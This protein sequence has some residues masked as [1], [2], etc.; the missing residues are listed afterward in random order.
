MTQASHNLNYE[1]RLKYYYLRFLR[2][3][4]EPH[5][6]ALGMAFGVFAGMMPII[7]FQVALAVAIALLFKASKITAAIGTWISNPLNWYFMY[8][9][10]YKIG[11]SITGVKEGKEILTSVINSIS[12][13]DEIAVIWGKLLSASMPLISSLLIGGIIMGIVASVPS[14]FIFLKVFWQIRKWRQK[15]K[16]KKAARNPMHRKNIKAVHTFE[17]KQRHK[18]K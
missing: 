17:E 6:L 7:P 14:Y 1:R 10:A 5:E 9:Y 11:A 16:E 13:G 12:R 18:L 8:L 3:R 2:L 4:G 15:R